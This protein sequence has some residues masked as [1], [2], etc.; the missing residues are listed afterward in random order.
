MSF[1]LEDLG[2]A[3]RKAKVDLYYSSHASL[4]AIADY[5]EALHANLASLLA[6]LNGDDESWVTKAEF[7]GDWTLATKL[8]DMSCWKQYREQHGNGL[9]FSSPAEEWAHVCELLAGAEKPQKPKAEFRVMAQCSLDFHVLSTLW[10][11]EVGHLFDAKLTG[12]AYGNR[13]RRT[14]DGKG[15]NQ[16]SLGSF[17]PYLKPFRDWR[18]QGIEAMRSA[19]EADKKIVALTA[20]VSSFYHE[21]N[22]GFMLNPDFITDVLGLV[23]DT[24]Q[25]K[26]HRLFIQALQAWA[27]TTPLERGLPVGLP[28][29]AVVA[30]VALVELDRIVEQQVAPLYYGRYVDDILLVMENG[31]SFRSTAELWGWLFARSNGKLDWVEGEVNKQICFQPSYLSDSQIR[32][33]NTKNKVF[34]LAGEPGKTLVDAIAHQIHERASEWRA[35]PRLPRSAGHVGTD[36]LAATQSDGEAADNLRKADALTMRRAGFAIKLRDFEAYERDLLPEAWQAH[37]QAFFRAF[38]QH[39]LVLPQFFDL[40]VYLPRVIRLA[41]ACEDFDALRKILRALEQL[42]TQLTQH[43]ELG[44]KACTTGSVPPDK[45]LMTRWQKQ[46]YTTVRESISAAFPPRLSK[47]GKAAWQAH[48]AD[49]LPVLDIDALLNWYLSPKGFQSQQARLF[50]FDLAHMPFRF[51]GLPKEMV[52][53]RGIPAKKTVVHCDHAAELLPDA[54]LDGSQRLARWIRCQGLPHGLLFAT[55]PYNLP[56]L[57]ILKRL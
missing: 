26:L 53:Q 27:K 23:L 47:E 56:E 38:V 2:L 54:V 11:L 43:C 57:F 45:D 22:P 10:M 36:L 24:Q 40:A 55:R 28:A 33:A 25:E 16:L 19:L 35:M 52:A 20:D 51:I 6:R 18:D 21:L 5:E 46:I 31:A 14:Q 50:S 48:M 39:V 12:C 13:L 34:M 44:I 42:C 3:Y 15:I 29:S 41:T 49:Y 17:Q 37:R 8:V 7:I 32:F 9:I 30:N 1:S 4:E